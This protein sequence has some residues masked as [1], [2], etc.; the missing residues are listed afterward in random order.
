MRPYMKLKGFLERNSLWYISNHWCQV[1][2]SNKSSFY[3]SYLETLQIKE[4]ERISLPRNL[5]RDQILYI[6]IEV[7]FKMYVCINKRDFI[8]CQISYY[9]YEEPTAWRGPTVSSF[10]EPTIG[11]RFSVREEMVHI[12]NEHSSH[13]LEKTWENKT[14]L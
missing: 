4:R 8:L 2:L 13:I 11:R 7:F 3:L 5:F 14:I 12:V 9:F 1:K 6:F 10:M